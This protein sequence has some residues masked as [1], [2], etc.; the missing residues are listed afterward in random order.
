MHPVVINPLSFDYY[1]SA[2]Y[3]QANV[4]QNFQTLW[5]ILNK[6]YSEEDQQIIGCPTLEQVLKPKL[7][8]NIVFFFN[9]EKVRNLKKHS[10]P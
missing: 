4:Q 10:M 8:L 9:M 5:Q 2:M 6:D 1:A 3:F 7:A